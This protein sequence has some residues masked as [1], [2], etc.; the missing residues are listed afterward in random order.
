MGRRK[1]EGPVDA[2]RVRAGARPDA[3]RQLPPGSRSTIGKGRHCD[4]PARAG[5]GSS[6]PG[7]YVRATHGILAHDPILRYHS[8]VLRPA[9]RAAWLPSSSF[10]LLNMAWLHMRCWCSCLRQ[11]SQTETRRQGFFRIRYVCLKDCLRHEVGR[12]CDGIQRL[13]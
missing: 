5:R 9:K 10:G 2:S 1:G 8:V 3:R 13:A 4:C 11:A 12:R 7:A 6:R